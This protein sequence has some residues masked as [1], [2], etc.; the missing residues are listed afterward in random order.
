MMGSERVP[1][2][3]IVDALALVHLVVIRHSSSTTRARDARGLNRDAVRV[4]W[5]GVV[6]AS[7]P[8]LITL[9]LL[10]TLGQLLSRHHP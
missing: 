8:S 10:P 3:F 1:V 6:S 2:V 7:F 4:E 5:S 9:N